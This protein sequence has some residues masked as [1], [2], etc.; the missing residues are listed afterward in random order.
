MKYTIELAVRGTG[1]QLLALDEEEKDQLLE[2]DLDDVY[3]DW[4]EEK[5]GDLYLEGQYLMRDSDRF[6]LTITDENGNEVF[7]T[8]DPRTLHDYTYN[9]AGEPQVEGWK[10][11]GVGDG[12]YLT[13]IQT[14][15][16]CYYTGEFEL[17]EPFDE[18]KFYILQSD[19]INDELLGDDV[20]DPYFVYYQRGEGYDIKRDKIELED[21]DW[22]D[23]QYWST[24]LMEVSHR[25]CWTDLSDK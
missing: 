22:V 25:D 21:D 9:D 6:C 24:H 12:L 15:K 14:L 19:T 20:Y 5:G 3:M 2:E 23:E 7:E 13:R 1:V 11:V 18:K 4:Y 10:F 16:G 8:E 17:D